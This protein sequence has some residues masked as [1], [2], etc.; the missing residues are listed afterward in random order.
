MSFT[1]PT[2]ASVVQ[3][4]DFVHFRV[5]WTQAHEIKPE[6]AFLWENSA[7]EAIHVIGEILGSSS[8]ELLSPIPPC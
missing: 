6:M 4:A 7:K 8:A 5:L 3:L 2:F 1:I